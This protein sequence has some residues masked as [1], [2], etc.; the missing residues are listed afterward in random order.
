MCKYNK[1]VQDLY[2]RKHQTVMKEI[3]KDLNEW[4]DNTCSEIGILSIFNISGLSNFIYGFNTILIITPVS[5][6]VEKKTNY[7]KIYT[8]IKIHNSQHITA[9][10]P[11]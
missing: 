11:S 2:V 1:Y 7:A 8:E 9:K 4:R 6:F 5:I 3:R 10:E